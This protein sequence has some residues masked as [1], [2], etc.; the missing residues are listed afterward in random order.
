MP[1]DT[2][3]KTEGNGR[4]PKTGRFVEGNQGGPGR[5]RKIDFIS[6]VRNHADASGVDLDLAVW[7]VSEALKEKALQ[8]DSVAARLWLDR[9]CGLQKQEVDVEHSGAVQSG[10]VPPS[11]QDAVEWAR[12]VA[13]MTERNTNGVEE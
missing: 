3:K 6:A 5:P 2:P 1:D 10:P 4:D 12:K 11:G 9:C 13:V 8:G 7:E